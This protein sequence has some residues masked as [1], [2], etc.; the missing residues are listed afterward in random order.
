VTVHCIV[1][2]N[3][4]IIIFFIIYELCI[5]CRCNFR[6][7]IVLDNFICFTIYYYTAKVFVSLQRSLR[8]PPV[9]VLYILPE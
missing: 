3:V 1:Y 9:S 6:A 5:L 4:L 8:R 7:N 2:S